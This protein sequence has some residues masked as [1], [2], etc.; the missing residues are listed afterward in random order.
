MTVYEFGGKTECNNITELKEVL[1]RR[2]KNGSNEFELR[3]KINLL[4]VSQLFIL[5]IDWLG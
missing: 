5:T 2:I 1:L 3:T 4:K